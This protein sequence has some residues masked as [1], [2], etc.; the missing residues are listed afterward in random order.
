MQLQICDIFVGLTSST[1]ID[2]FLLDLLFGGS[3]TG[4]VEVFLFWDIR[5]VKVEPFLFFCS[6]IADN[7]R[8]GT[9]SETLDAFLFRDRMSVKV[10]D[11]LLPEASSEDTETLFCVFLEFR[12]L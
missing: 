7:L 5:S 8:F 1:M 12:S 11:F 10:E 2:G 3:L 6:G 4:V 9:S